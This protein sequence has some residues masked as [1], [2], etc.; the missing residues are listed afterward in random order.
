MDELEKLITNRTKIISL[1]HM[2]NV[3]G[4]IIDIKKVVEI[5]KK[6]QIPVCVDGTQ[7]AAHLD[8]NLQVKLMVQKEL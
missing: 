1:T 4:T 6:N 2:S 8:L 3:T 7:G 5:A